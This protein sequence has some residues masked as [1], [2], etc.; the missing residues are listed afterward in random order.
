[1]KNLLAKSVYYTRTLDNDWTSK[2]NDLVRDKIDSGQVAIYQNVS[3]LGKQTQTQVY[4]ISIKEVYISIK[5]SH[6][7]AP[8]GQKT[9]IVGNDKNYV[10]KIEFFRLGFLE[11]MFDF[12]QMEHWYHEI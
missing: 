4:I 1:M 2:M 5:N 7:S 12:I 9:D 8:S 10:V 3:R 6:Q 11:T